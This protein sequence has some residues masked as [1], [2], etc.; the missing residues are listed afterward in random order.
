V[1]LVVTVYINLTEVRD[2][3]NTPIKANCILLFWFRLLIDFQLYLMN[4]SRRLDERNEELWNLA[5]KLMK[6]VKCKITS[7]CSTIIK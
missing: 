4:E 3:E 2:N 5:R 7:G 1:W 6:A